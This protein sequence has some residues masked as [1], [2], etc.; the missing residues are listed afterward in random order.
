MISKD[1]SWALSVR[2]TVVICKTYV[3]KLQWSIS[4]S[5]RLYESR[6]ASH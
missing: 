3:V 4:S 6:L 5:S 2:V 1:R